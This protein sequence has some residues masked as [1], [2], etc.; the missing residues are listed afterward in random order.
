MEG[1]LSANLLFFLFDMILDLFLYFRGS[2]VK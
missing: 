1:F 2:K